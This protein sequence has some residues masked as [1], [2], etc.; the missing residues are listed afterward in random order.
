[1]VH[2]EHGS[3]VSQGMTQGFE[4]HHQVV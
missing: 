2:I 3:S 4:F 1:M